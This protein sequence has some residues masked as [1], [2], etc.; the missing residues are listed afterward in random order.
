[1]AETGLPL[2]VERLA[3]RVATIGFTNAVIVGVKAPAAAAELQSLLGESAVPPESEIT[4]AAAAFSMQFDE[5]GSPI[6][7]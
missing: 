5:S 7:F 4:G 2:A 3:R 1:M 6:G